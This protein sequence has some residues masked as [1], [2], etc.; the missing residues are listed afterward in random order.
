MS[1]APHKERPPA[2]W[3]TAI[4]LTGPNAAGKGEVAAYLMTRGYGYHSL[5]DVVRQEAADRGLDSSRENLVRVGNELRQ[6]GGPGILVRRLLS[7]LALPAVIDS[8][9]NPGEAEALAQLDRFVLLA[10]EAPASLRF[11]RIQ[12]RG[13]LGDIASLEEFRR[14]ENRENSASGVEQRIKATMEKAD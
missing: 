7:H 5:S 4:G 8:V 10:V 14:F 6:T 1:R 12:A 3:P 9:R 2:H 13:R 11:R